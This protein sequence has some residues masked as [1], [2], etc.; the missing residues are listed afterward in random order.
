MKEQLYSA[1]QPARL[2]LPGHD[3][4]G[5]QLCLKESKH[6]IHNCLAL[7]TFL[8]RQLVATGYRRS[9]GGPCIWQRPPKSMQY[10]VQK[11]NNGSLI[12]TWKSHTKCLN[13]GRHC[14][15]CEHTTY[16]KSSTMCMVAHMLMTV[17]LI[18]LL[19]LSLGSSQL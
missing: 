5:V 17:A 13:G 18:A 11:K 7:I 12:I 4:P 2:Y 14:V 15:S 9:R 1:M 6:L 19:A 3:L 8:V 10:K 16:K